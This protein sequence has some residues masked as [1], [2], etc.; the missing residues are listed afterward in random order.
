[1]PYT[2]DKRDYKVKYVTEKEAKEISED[3]RFCPAYYP[4]YDV[5]GT[6][7]LIDGEIGSLGFT[8]YVLRKERGDNHVRA[9]IR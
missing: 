1:M 9:N 8:R 6:V 3:M 2:I 7:L 4:S 5:G